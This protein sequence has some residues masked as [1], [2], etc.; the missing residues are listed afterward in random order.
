M[1]F[2]KSRVLNKKK[3]G[4]I[5]HLK[6]PETLDAWLKTKISCQKSAA[7]FQVKNY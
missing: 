7:I 4:G 3:H 2:K 1:N 6:G 5:N